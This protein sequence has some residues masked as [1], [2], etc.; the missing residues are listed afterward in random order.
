MSVR[1]FVCALFKWKS[2]VT[3]HMSPYLLFHAAFLHPDVSHKQQWAAET[4]DKRVSRNIKV[5]GSAVIINYQILMP[6]TSS[7]VSVRSRL[8]HK[9]KKRKL[10]V[11]ASMQ[12][13]LTN[14]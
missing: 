14:E 9:G 11:S 2:R 12:T 7:V 1:M 4:S 6:I 10:Y 5:S 13:W 8:R 3:T